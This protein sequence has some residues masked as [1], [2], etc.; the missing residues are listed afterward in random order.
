[1]LFPLNSRCKGVEIEQGSAV[2][3]RMADFQNSAEAVQAFFFDLIPS[4]Q[5]GV[6]SEVAQ[7]PVEFPQCSRGAI[8]AAGNRVP[9]EFF[10]FE[11]REAED[12]ERFS[13]I[14]SM[15]SP[16]DAKE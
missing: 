1:M 15:L 2:Y 5:F 13:C 4:E 16:I 7:K 12:I 9:S 3:D 10:G 8:K 6:V 11:D 14:P